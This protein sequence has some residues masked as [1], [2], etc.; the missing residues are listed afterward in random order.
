[1]PKAS[2]GN[3][4]YLYLIKHNISFKPNLIRHDIKH[5]LLGYEMDMPDEL[6]IHSFLIGNRSYNTMGILYLIICTAIIPE[7]IP[8]LILAYKRGKK[9]DCM[10]RINFYPL[11]RKPLIECQ[12]KLKLI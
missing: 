4:L 6:K 7:T 1:M 5:I 8:S 11:V 10:K 3:E 9:A 12:Q 2:L